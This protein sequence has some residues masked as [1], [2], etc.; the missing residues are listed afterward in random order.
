MTGIHRIRSI[1][2]KAAARSQEEGLALRKLFRDDGSEFLLPLLEEAF[3]LACPVNEVAHVPRLE[4]RLKLAPQ[5]PFT[6]DAAAPVLT[7]VGEQLGQLSSREKKPKQMSG[8]PRRAI[9]EARLEALLRYVETGILPWEMQ[10]FQ[11]HEAAEELAAAAA[12]NPG[13]VMDHIMAARVGSAGWMRLFSLLPPIG[14]RLL[15]DLIAGRGNVNMLTLM[16]A[17]VERGNEYLPHAALLRLFSA[18]AEAATTQVNFP[19]LSNVALTQYEREMATLFASTLPEPLMHLMLSGTRARPSQLPNGPERAGEMDL[20]PAGELAAEASRF[21]PPDK[22]LIEPADAY[23]ASMVHHPFASG[24]AF[25][26]TA[27]AASRPAGRN[28]GKIFPLLVRN[29]G[30]VL[31][32]P[33]IQRFLVKTGSMP[34]DSIE[35]PFDT[36]PRAAALLSFL[37]T[38]DH[39]LQEFELPL[40]K[41]LLGI[42]PRTAVPVAEEALEE[43][44]KDEAKALLQAVVNHWSSLKGTSAEG[45]RSSFLRRAGLLR[46][47]DGAWRLDVE[48]KSYDI[49]LEQ[50]PWTI[51]VAKLP[52][53]N[54]SVLVQW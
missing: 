12:A 51:S 35:I 5:M 28:V 43:R 26:G 18:V 48:R 36:L 7:Q 3:D 30:L 6:E 32:I 20:R 34:A 13:R 2:W 22:S 17:L 31:L 45:F 38:G 23:A 14:E 37:A 40:V 42:D 50:L 46:E 4:I 29:A 39:C 1:R 49:L 53:M 41:V 21:N 54:K 11:P 15:P 24:L 16:R 27:V 44:D 19:I 25:D 8:P 47:E 52:W 10:G 9:E 33:F